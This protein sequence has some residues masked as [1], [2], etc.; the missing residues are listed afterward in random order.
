MQQ[1][2]SLK[3]AFQLFEGEGILLHLKAETRKFPPTY[4]QP[5]RKLDC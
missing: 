3:N 1:G 5:Q 2:D 4:L